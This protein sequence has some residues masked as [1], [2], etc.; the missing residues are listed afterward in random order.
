MDN[1]GDSPNNLVDEL[2]EGLEFARQLQMNLHMPSSSQETSYMLIQK[3]IL[4][5]EKA[6]QMVNLKGG[7]LIESSSPLLS[8]SPQSEGS[9]RDF[10]DQDHNASRKRKTLPI[11]T[12]IIQVNPR[13]GVEGPLDDG[14]S[15]R[16]YGQKDILGAVYPRGYYKCIHRNVRGCLATKQVQRSDE[17]TTIFEITYRGMHTCTMA[18]NTV[19]IST[20]NENQESNLDT[21]PHQQINILQSLEHQPNPNELLLNLREGLRVQTEN[22][23][24]SLHDQSF[25]SFYFPSTSNIKTENQIF[26]SPMLENFTSPSYITPTTSGISHFSVSQSMTSSEFQINDMNLA[27]TSAANSSTIGLECPF[28]QFQFDGHDFTFD[29][30]RFF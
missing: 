16:K 4:A 12:K 17:D 9:D 25:G 26:P 10:R 29:N 23:D 19:P 21:I 24:S 7:P 30:P 14:Y 6:L 1:M 28:D 8:C 2:L 3:I 22:L 27:A 11:W 13:M 5:F 18:S 15:W 20:T